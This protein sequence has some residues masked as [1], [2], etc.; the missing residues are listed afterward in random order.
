MRGEHSFVRVG[1]NSR[2]VGREVVFA[3][4]CHNGAKAEFSFLGF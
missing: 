1:L 3:E 4:R 2:T